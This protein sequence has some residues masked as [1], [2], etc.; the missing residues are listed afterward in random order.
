[1]R[2]L[3][4]DDVPLNLKLLHRMLTRM[5][6][7]D[8]D[9]ASN[10]AEA[11]ELELAN[12]YDL[13]I[14]DLQMPVMGGTEAINTIVGSHPRPGRHLPY[15]V[16]LTADCTAGVKERCLSAGFH[17]VLSKPC[18]QKVLLSA[19]HAAVYHSA[20]N[21][22]PSSASRAVRA[23]RQCGVIEGTDAV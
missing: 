8:P 21:H 13:I 9:R 15:L 22:R 2:V 16:A 12:A 23:A 4:V 1:M 10:G 3:I 7:P 19:L 14:C 5:G 11:V 6:L 17:M 18:K 20:S